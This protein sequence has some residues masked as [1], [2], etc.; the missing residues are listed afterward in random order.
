MVIWRARWT[1][2]TSIDDCIVWSLFSSSCDNLH[3][4][5]L[6]AFVFR[7]STS[8]PIA[9]H[10]ASIC[11]NIWECVV[12]RPL[13]TSPVHWCCANDVPP[14]SIWYATVS[15]VSTRPAQANILAWVCFQFP[16]NNAL[17][18]NYV[19]RC[20]AMRSQPPYWHHWQ[21]SINK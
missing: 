15:A 5:R 10:V 18:S 2:L 1:P 14:G 4:V 11:P 9:I 6:L 19:S 12:W 21:Y 13:W 17:W 16:S 3:S 7:S 20:L 8:I